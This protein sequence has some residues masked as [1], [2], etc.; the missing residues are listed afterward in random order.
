MIQDESLLVM[1]R[2]NQRIASEASLVQAAINSAFSKEGAKTFT[3]Q[4]KTLQMDVRPRIEQ[5]PT[6]AG[7]LEGQ[8]GFEDDEYD[9]SDRDGS[10]VVSK[11]GPKLAQE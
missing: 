10:D 5:T 2:E 9:D 4:L 1:Q 8:H 7:V 6:I 11:Y 3:K